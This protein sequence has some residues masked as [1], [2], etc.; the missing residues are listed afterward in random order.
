MTLGKGV[1][2]TSSCDQNVNTKTS[3]EG[4]LVTID[5]GMAQI[6]WIHQFLAAQGHYLPTTALYQEQKFYLPARKH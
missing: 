6:L 1:I 4:A 5:D 2:Y 3:M